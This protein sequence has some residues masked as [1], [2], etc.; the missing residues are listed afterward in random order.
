MAATEAMAPKF[1]LDPFF[2]AWAGRIDRWRILNRIARALAARRAHNEGKLRQQASAAP[3]A[4]HPIAKLN[5]YPGPHWIAQVQERLA[6][7]GWVGLDRLVQR[8]SSALPSN[9]Y[10]DDRQAWIVEDEGESHLPDSLPPSS[11]HGQSR[12]P[13]FEVLLSTGRD[14]GHVSRAHH[15][16]SSGIIAMD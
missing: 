15:R 10:R 1:E 16:N 2:P 3:E 5:A 13:Y 6:N 7:G 9:S 12:K 8:I 4:P 14:I 11:G